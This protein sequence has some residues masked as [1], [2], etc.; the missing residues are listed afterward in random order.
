MTKTLTEQW[1][2]GELENGYYYVMVLDNKKDVFMLH[3]IHGHFEYSSSFIKEVLASVP[4]YE[5]YRELLDL[6]VYEK[7]RKKAIGLENKIKRLQ[8]QLKE[9][10]KIVNM[11]WEEESD[12]ES[13]IFLEKWGYGHD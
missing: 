13:R 3:L 4:S 9:A 2:D 5:E 6:N 10:V 1:K 11:Y 7:D 8:E 12:Q